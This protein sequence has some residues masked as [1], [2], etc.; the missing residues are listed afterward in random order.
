[1]VKI[2]VVN[3]LM[4]TPPLNR[5][6]SPEAQSQHHAEPAETAAAAEPVVRSKTNQKPRGKR[7]KAKVISRDSTAL[8]MESTECKE[9][10]LHKR[11]VSLSDGF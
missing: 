6:P 4:D 11:R 1:M 2:L 7:T 9:G 3:Y 8:P 10:S 5:S